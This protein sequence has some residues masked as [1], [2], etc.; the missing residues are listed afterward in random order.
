VSSGGHRR[1][2]E[3]RSG[4]L[5]GL[6]SS[7]DLVAQ[8]AAQG[9][10]RFDLRI[11]LGDS[12]GNVVAA[13]PSENVP[14]ASLV[15]LVLGT[16]SIAETGV[17]VKWIPRSDSFSTNAVAM[18]TGAVILGVLS[19]VFAERWAVPIEGATWAAVGYLVVIGS[20]VT[21]GLYVFTS[22]AGRHPP[23]RTRR[24]YCR[25]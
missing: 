15:L 13:G 21:F 14:I 11:A 19:V 16:L 5:I 2:A 12:F 7:V 3:S 23:C 4:H 8:P 10:D 6:E 22:S 9:P 24:C 20:V 17:I 25:W 18:L 1:L